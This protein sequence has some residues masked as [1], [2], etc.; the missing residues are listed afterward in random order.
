M[1]KVVDRRAGEGAVFIFE[2]DSRGHRFYFVRVLAD[3]LL[4][5]GRRPILITSRGAMESGQAKEFLAGLP[6]SFEVQETSATA[7]RAVSSRAQRDGVTQVVVPDGDRHLVST[8]LRIGRRLPRVTVLVMRE[9]KLSLSQ[10]MPSAARQ[11]L[12]LI[13]MHALRARAS[14]QVVVLKSSVWKGRSLFPVAQDPVTLAASLEDVRRIHDLWDLDPARRWFAV[15]GAITPRKNLPL[16]AEAFARTASEGSGLL[17]GGAVE[18]GEMVRALPHLTEAERRGGRVVVKD[19]MLTDVELDAAIAAVDCVILA[20]SNE[21]PSGIFGKAVMSGT[22]LVTAG[23]IS[24]RQDAAAAPEHAAW[25]ELTVDS[26]SLEMTRAAQ[27]PRPPAVPDMG[28]ARF[29]TA[30]L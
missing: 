16:I 28:T 8:L 22:R 17:I 12:K 9:P 7:L 1:N 13:S 2:P 4:A 25:C 29:T 26:L 30:L 3:A 6:A 24:L 15:V 5:K 18:E 23:A 19:R 14:A 20:H 10:P 21:G 11:W 27:R